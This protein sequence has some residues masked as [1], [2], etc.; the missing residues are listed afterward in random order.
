MRQGLLDHPVCGS[1][2]Y[3]VALSEA[4]ID[5]NEFAFVLPCQGASGLVAIGLS[6]VDIRRAAARCFGD[7][8]WGIYRSLHLRRVVG[9]SERSDW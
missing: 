7:C 3:A 2:R 4:S 5:Q 6:V 9:D 8:E 1:T